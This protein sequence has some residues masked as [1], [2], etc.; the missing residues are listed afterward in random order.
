MDEFS[1]DRRKM[2]FGLAAAAV[3]RGIPVSATFRT[4]SVGCT[5]VFQ[6]RSSDGTALAGD[7]QGA[8]RAHQPLLGTRPEGDDR[9]YG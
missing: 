2:L 7:A 3:V 1:F 9:L 5:E 6:V 4:T 8:C